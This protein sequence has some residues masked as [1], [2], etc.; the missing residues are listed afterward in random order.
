MLDI[1]LRPEKYL[2]AEDVGRLVGSGEHLVQQMYRAHLIDAAELRRGKVVFS[3]TEAHRWKKWYLECAGDLEKYLWASEK[4]L[5]G[6]FAASA[7]VALMLGVI[8]LWK[9]GIPVLLALSLI[10]PAAFLVPLPRPRPGRRFRQVQVTV[11][12]VATG[13]F[14]SDILHHVLGHNE[15]EIGHVALVMMICVLVSLCLDKPSYRMEEYAVSLEPGMYMCFMAAVGGL[16]LAWGGPTLG[17]NIGFIP[18]LIVGAAIFAAAALAQ[19]MRQTNTY[20]FGITVPVAAYFG[21]EAAVIALFTVAGLLVISSLARHYVA[22]KEDASL[23]EL[24][25]RGGW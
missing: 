21:W 5:A 16:A 9:Q 11:A 15:P 22:E 3:P 20:A 25:S 23:A 2:T 7:S 18:A 1:Q 24:M 17:V 8:G 6:F 14:L 4:I 10:L 12:G 13:L 19:L